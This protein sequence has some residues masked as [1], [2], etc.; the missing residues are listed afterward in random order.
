MEA[1]A[2]GRGAGARGS[3]R[4]RLRGDDE[5]EGAVA[6]ALHHD[7]DDVRGRRPVARPGGAH[8]P[9]RR[10]V[11]GRRRVRSTTR[12]TATSTRVMK[13]TAEP[14]GRVG[15]RLAARALVF[16]I[17]LGCAS[18]ALLAAGGQPAAAVL[19]MSGLLGYVLV[20]TVWLKRT[21]PQ[22]IVIGGAAGAMPPLVAWAAVTGCLT[23]T[24]IY[25]FAIVFYWTPPHFW[26]LSLLMKDE[27][28]RAGMPMLPV[29]RGEQETR[30]QILLYRCC[31]RGH[32][33]AVL[34]RR[35]SAPSTWSP[36]W[37]SAGRSIA[38]RWCCT[39]ERTGARR[40]APTSTRWPTW[41]CCSARWWP[42]R[43]WLVYD[44]Q[45]TVVSSPARRPVVSS[46]ASV[47]AI[48]AACLAFC[49]PALAGDPLTSIKVNEVESDGAADF[50]ELINI[51]AT[52][53]DVSGLILKDND[54]SRT[55]AIPDTRA[56]PRAASWR[57]TPTSPAGSAG[58]ERL[59][60]RLHAQRRHSDRRLHLD[61]ARRDQLRPLPRRLRSFV[62]TDSITK[63][64]AN[65][66]PPSRARPTRGHPNAVIASWRP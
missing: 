12:S 42:T 64:A 41:R 36:R 35:R 56:L 11:G 24:A 65:D 29:V 22:N 26:A 17:L 14:P 23:G 48:L 5:A 6:A 8:L 18:F 21:T 20:Y 58:S 45:E 62:T 61:S 38:L 2:D 63:G 34:R 44:R 19:A 15:P 16:G 7:H 66:C 37:P 13:R 10:A 59:R 52:A 46:I 55:L 39:G 1:G 54:D 9:G 30:R 33:A 28:A 47:A 31:S 32:P 43:G 49:P 25:L 50:I 51:S 27:Y 3:G 4:L 53:T 60:S 57:W 40:C